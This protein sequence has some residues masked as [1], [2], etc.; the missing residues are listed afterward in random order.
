MLIQYIVPLLITACLAAAVLLLLRTM[1]VPADGSVEI[2]ISGDEKAD[3]I[4]SAVAMAK[5]LS[6]QY[7]KDA[8][9]YIRGGE[10]TYVNALCRRYDVCRKE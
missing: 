6:E 9:V 4:E 7:F 8:K 3:N 1:G 10:S 5:R 2:I